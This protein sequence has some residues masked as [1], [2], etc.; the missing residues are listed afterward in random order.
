MLSSDGTDIGGI[1][2]L[3]KTHG[4]PSHWIAYVAVDD[5]NAAAER[6]Q[7]GGGETVVPPTEIKNVGT[8]AVLK[9]PTGG[10]ISAWKGAGPYPAENDDPTP[11]GRFI[12]EE[13]LTTDVDAAK[14]FYSELFSWS[15]KEMDMGEMGPYTI[16][17]SGGRDRA[18]MMK[19]PDEDP[20]PSHWLSYVK[21]DDV[22]ALAARTKELGGVV[23]VEPR[24]IP[25][26]GRFCVGA[27]TS[28]AMFAVYKPAPS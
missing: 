7:A 27:D 22:D 9:D 5:V 16:F 2:A 1:V 6:A 23:F 20:H 24:D 28:G 4:V 15:T 11:A 25:N 8:F 17:A 19:K 26:I 21:A 10:F 18:G 3:D 13:L 14:R 12:W